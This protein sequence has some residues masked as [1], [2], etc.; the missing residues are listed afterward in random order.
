MKIL[1]LVSTGVLSKTLQL[2]LDKKNIDY[3]TLSRQKSKNK[4]INLK[5]ISNFKKLKQNLTTLYFRMCFKKFPVG[6][7]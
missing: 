1:I 4:N 5:N 3:L 6:E 2:Y 7:V